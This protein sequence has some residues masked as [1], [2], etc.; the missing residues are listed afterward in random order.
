MAQ[1]TVT[2]IVPDRG[3]GFIAADGEEYFF[4]QSALAGG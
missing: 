1:G 2:R 4:N 3:F